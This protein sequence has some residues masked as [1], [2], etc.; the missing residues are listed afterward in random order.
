MI[1]L[2]LQPMAG[3]RRVCAL[4]STRSVSTRR[5]PTSVSAKLATTGTIPGCASVSSWWLFQSSLMKAMIMM[6]MVVMMVVVVIEKRTG[7]GVE[8]GGGGGGGIISLCQAG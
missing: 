4:E 3:A 2:V 1:L 7:P 8:D 6:M 5:V